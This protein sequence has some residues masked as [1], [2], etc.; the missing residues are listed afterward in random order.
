MIY[1]DTSAFI[2]FF[3]SKDFNHNKAQK[4]FSEIIE[5]NLVS[6]HEVVTETLNWFAKKTNPKLVLKIGELLLSGE[7][8][9]IL[10]TG[11]EEWH[12]AL[13]LIEKYKDHKLSYT[14]ALSFVLIKK[15]KIEQVFSMDKDFNLLKGTQ[16]LFHQS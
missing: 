14:G 5:N 1:I 8:I 15:F 3:L 16:N 4:I 10:E 13:A 12:A 7:P 2:A 9:K 11:V 6:S